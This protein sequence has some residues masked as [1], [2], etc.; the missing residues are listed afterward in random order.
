MYRP[1]VARQSNL[2]ISKNKTT[3]QT[4]Q[5]KVLIVAGHRTGSTFISELFNQ[6]SEAFFIFEPLGSVQPGEPTIGCHNATSKKICQ[7]KGFFNC[8]TPTYVH[9]MNGLENNNCTESVFVESNH[10]GDCHI[11]NL[12]FRP[13]ARWSCNP[14]LCKTPMINQTATLLKNY[15]IDEY[16]GKSLTVEQCL[17]CEKLNPLFMDLVCKTKKIIAVKGI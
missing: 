10:P 5:I 4:N 8:K 14:R 2:T 12:C 17:H 13:D 7:L 15:T 6:N 11:K 16:E 1:I 3:I 9:N